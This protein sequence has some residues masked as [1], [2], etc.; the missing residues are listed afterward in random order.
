M[1]KNT[2]L[3][4]KIIH[5]FADEIY[6]L[7]TRSGFGKVL[8]TEID[9][10]MFHAFLMQNL[11]VSCKIEDEIDY[12]AIDKNVIY[13]LSLAARVKESS[14]Q[15]ML[16]TDFLHYGSSE[17]L[18]EKL[19]AAVIDMAKRARTNADEIRQTGK[20]RILVANPI[21][22]KLI[23]QKLAELGSFCDFSFNKNILVVDAKSFALIAFDEK[24]LRESLFEAIH[25]EDK[26]ITKDKFNKD[27][28]N[29]GIKEILIGPVKFVT[30]TAINA[31]MKEI[32]DR[33]FPTN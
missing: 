21:T 16:E 3:Q 5:S 24:D 27:T 11:P 26:S 14:L 2:K 4:E 15:T 7:Y 28:K 18:D 22:K 23:E 20:V 25:N 29:S 13:T 30:E 10:V 32:F 19:K 12:L 17:N 1:E 8:K 33:V 31:A 9:R 6:T